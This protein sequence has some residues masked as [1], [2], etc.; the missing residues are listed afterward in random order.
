MSADVADGT[1]FLSADSSQATDLYFVP[2]I[3]PRATKYR[4]D[5]LFLHITS[6]TEPDQVLVT[7]LLQA[8][9]MVIKSGLAA[10]GTI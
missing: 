7:R 6:S 1:T 9:K 3:S 2:E 10:R 5:C 8:P 4:T